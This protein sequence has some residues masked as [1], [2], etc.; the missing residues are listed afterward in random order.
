MQE[1][2]SSGKKPIE[3]IQALRARKAKF[4]RVT[5]VSKCKK[6]ELPLATVGTT[7][8]KARR[9]T[10]IDILG[11]VRWG[12]HFCVFYQSKQD[13]ID[14][15][16]PYF[17]EGLENNEFCMWISSEPLSA[18]DA[19]KSLSQ[20]VTNLDDYIKKGQIE[21]LDY[22]DWYT[23]TG[24]FEAD[25]VLKGWVQKHDEAIKRGFDGLRLTRNTLWL[26]KK[27]WVKFADYEAVVNSVICKYRMLAICTYSL[28]KCGASEILDV[29]NNHQFSLIKWR[30]DWK[31]LE[32]SS[33]NQ[34]EA[35]LAEQT[36]IA[37]ALERSKK[38]WAKTFNAM[39]DWVVLIDL[40]GRILR[41][42]QAGENF[43]GKT[44]DE[45]IG[46]SCCK[47]V[48]GSDKHVSG[49]PLRIMLHTRQRAATELNVPNTNRWVMVSTDPVIDEKGNLIGA[50]HVTRDITERKKGEKA[51]RESEKGY[52]YLF[53]QSLLGIGLAT[54]DGKVI[55]ANKTMEVITGYFEEELKK[56]NL[57]DTYENPADKKELLETIERYGCAVDFPT[58]LK[59]KDGTIYD[60]LLN[61]SRVHLAGKDLFQTICM[62]ITERKRAEV[63]RLLSNQLLEI[64]NRQTQRIAL[65]KELV[66]EIQDFTGCAAVGIRMLDEQGNIPYEAHV[67]FSRKFY[68]SENPLSTKRDKCM[69][70]NVIKGDTDP[71]QPFYTKGGSFYMN[72][73]TKFLATVSEEDKGQT[74]NVC[75]EVGYE[76]V[77]LVPIRVDNSI[78]GLVHIADTQENMVPLHMVEALEYVAVHLGTAIQRVWAEEALRES[79]EK[80]RDL[81]ENAQEAIITID[82]KGNITGA[83]KLVEEYGFKKNEL[84]DKSLFDFVPQY[85][86]ARAVSDFETLT[87]GNPVRGEMDIITP[88]GIITV[89]YNDN[90]IIRGEEIIGIQAILTDITERKKVEEQIAKLA[91]FPAENPNPVLRISARGTVIYGNKAGL[92]LLKVW[93]CRVGESVSAEWYEVVLDALSS[94]EN[95]QKEV[96]CDDRVLSLTFAPVMDANYVNIYGLDIT[97]RKRVEEKLRES[98]DYLEKLTNS[99]WDTVFSVKMPERV[100]EWANDSFRLIGYEPEECVGRTTKFL[101]PDESEFLDFG[102]KL[103]EA[104]AAGEGVLHAEQLL[105]RKNGEKFP[106]EI[107]T[108]LFREKGEI[109]RITS[110][111]RDITERR[112]VEEKL[113]NHQAQLK[114][115]ASQLTLTEERERRKIAADLHDHVS[116]S[117][118]FSK[119]KLQA[120]RKSESSA[121]AQQALDEVCDH[122]GQAI[123]DTKSLTFN[124]SSPVLNE[125]GFEAAVADWLTEQIE[126]KHNMKTEFEDDGQPK[127]LDDD[128]RLLLFR[129]VRELLINVVKHA[130]ANTVKISTSKGGTEIQVRIE[131]D[132]VGFDPVETM[133]MAAKRS[134]FGLFSIR[135]R[136]EELGGY[137]EIDSA[138]GRGCRVTMTAPLKG[139]KK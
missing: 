131:D 128:I 122:L 134:E 53:E 95:Q 64:A 107:T 86:K 104:I 70:I 15:L 118:S 81:F 14:I 75:N 105:K 126:K 44:L 65:L 25:S 135:E 21:I 35:R 32:S 61:V 34:L 12:T 1:S 29:E 96:K 89:D 49:C 55:R 72:G 112:Q 60:A 28:D 24:A 6:P 90:P 100:I 87:A 66:R 78:F 45:I 120:L 130:H 19:K 127:S 133:S 31:I 13:L 16:V 74:R 42:N 116:Q 17:K 77:A 136:L 111:V 43:S 27:D 39:S 3:E 56:I 50:V 62:D 26:E 79:E 8:E 46:Q 76:S 132:G 98:R 73:T 59:R 68:E 92:P 40:K 67:G 91:K 71:E 7:E 33:K 18:E 85:D 115:L 103:R 52:R 20:A 30:G 93:Q 38:D 117:L 101:Y 11:E 41:T 102:K 119:M 114:S 36:A 124:I 108:T 80:Y 37:Q 10:G 109:T 84:M 82:V 139:A 5:S 9:K 137:L 123:D 54:P 63:E 99:M 83:N 94:G 58:R 88:K 51:L 47:L 22:R 57:A 129:N 113:L 110:I 23:K 106:A 69:C 121:Q 2:N 48:H 4:E 97:E 125:L 138:P